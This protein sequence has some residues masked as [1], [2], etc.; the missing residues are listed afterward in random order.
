MLHSLDIDKH[1]RL[2]FAESRAIRYGPFQLSLLALL[3]LIALVAGVSDFSVA[4]S[5][6]ASV[7]VSCQYL[8]AAAQSGS[9][10]LQRLLEDALLLVDIRIFAD[11]VA[12][13]IVAGRPAVGGGKPSTQHYQAALRTVETWAESEEAELAVT[14]CANYVE[15]HLSSPQQQT[16]FLSPWASY[17]TAICLYCFNS[18]SSRRTTFARIQV[19]SMICKTEMVLQ[20]E[21]CTDGKY[22]SI[23]RLL[24]TL[25][26]VVADCCP[27]LM[28]FRR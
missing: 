21:Q 26:K 13:Q 2:G 20:H 18:V 27:C 23:Y 4:Q 14:L 11:I 22:L 7:H 12:L 24:T 6:R 19:R 15:K 8:S 3:P 28:T 5:V 16:S 25:P 1:D 10:Q 9:P 17:A